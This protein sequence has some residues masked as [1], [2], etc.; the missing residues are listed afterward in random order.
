MHLSSS[1]A[2]SAHLLQF[3]ELSHGGGGDTD[4]Q[5]G[6]QP[7]CKEESLASQFCF[8]AAL[9]NI[10]TKTAGEESRARLSCDARLLWFLNPGLL[11]LAAGLDYPSGS[12]SSL[13]LSYHLLWVRCFTYVAS[14]AF[15]NILC[16]RCYYFQY[17]IGGKTGTKRLKSPRKEASRPGSVPRSSPACQSC[18]PAS[19]ALAW[20]PHSYWYMQ[21]YWSMEETWGWMGCHK[22]GE[23]ICLY[24]FCGPK[25]ILLVFTVL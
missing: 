13:P 24:F 8:L 18:Y 3:R 21:N 19:T 10:P 16:Q 7:C 14:L 1:T 11:R 20:R 4:T 6:V 17:F 12:V 5:K 2:R 9:M 15:L 23:A 25:F 22:L